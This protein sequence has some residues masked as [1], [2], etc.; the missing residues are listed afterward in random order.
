MVEGYD[1]DEDLGYRGYIASRPIR[2]F[3]IDAASGELS[4]ALL[5]P[6]SWTR[7]QMRRPALAAI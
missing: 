5:C 1:R 7:K 3:G 2:S 6:A 4:T